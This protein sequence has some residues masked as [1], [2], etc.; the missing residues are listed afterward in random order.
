M[1]NPEVSSGINCQACLDNANFCIAS[2]IIALIG[3]GIVGGTISY[4]I[5]VVANKLFCTQMSYVTTV[6]YNPD[7]NEYTISIPHEIVNE[8]GWSSK[9]IL[10]WSIDNG[11]VILTKV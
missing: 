2:S 9:D 4:L 1:L 11:K 8:L 7:T 10:Q 3:G 6:G 5:S